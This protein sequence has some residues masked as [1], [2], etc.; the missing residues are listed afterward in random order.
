LGNVDAW[1]EMRAKTLYLRG[2]GLERR[3][4]GLISSSAP[5]ALLPP[6]PPRLVAEH[7]M[8]ENSAKIALCL[9]EISLA[10]TTKRLSP[11]ELA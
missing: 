10:L 3:P 7:I 2:A 6:P 11:R 5:G 8:Q 9:R 4:V 1:I